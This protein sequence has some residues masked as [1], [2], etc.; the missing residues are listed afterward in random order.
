VRKLVE[1]PPKARLVPVALAAPLLS[2][3]W[4][5][6]P[7]R[8]VNLKLVAAGRDAVGVM[9]ATAVVEL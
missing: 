9:V 6:A 2:T 8:T 4:V 3:A 7:S 5:T 1:N